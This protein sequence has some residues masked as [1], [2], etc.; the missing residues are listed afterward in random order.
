[1]SDEKS[2]RSRKNNSFKKALS[3]QATAS[4]DTSCIYLFP[5]PWTMLL[6]TYSLKTK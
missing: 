6:L 2:M 1:M 3:L 4:T 5:V